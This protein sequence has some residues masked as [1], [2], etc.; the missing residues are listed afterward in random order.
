MA[1]LTDGVPILRL[2]KARALPGRQTELAAKLATTSA[3]LVSAQPG[4][5]GYLAAGPAAEGARDFAFISVWSSFGAMKALF[6]ESW[7]D[8]RL[9]PGYAALIES[10][11][12]EHFHLTDRAAVEL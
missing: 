1:E 2:F 12:V 8:S 7:R 5:L 4:F 3:E 9:P 6:G 10:H 11:S